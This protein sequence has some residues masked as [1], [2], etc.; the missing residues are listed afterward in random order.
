MI[1]F[2]HNTLANIQSLMSIVNNE[3]TDIKRNNRKRTSKQIQSKER[4]FDF[5]IRFC[6]VFYETLS[7]IFKLNLGVGSL[8]WV[9]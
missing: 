5:I 1:A 2:R 3:N 8:I 9:T 4:F 6:G 7:G